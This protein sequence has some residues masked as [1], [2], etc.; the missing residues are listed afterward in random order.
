MVIVVAVVLGMI[1]HHEVQFVPVVVVRATS[2]FQVNELHPAP[3]AAMVMVW[4]TTSSPPMTII[5]SPVLVA[6]KLTEILAPPV[7][8]TFCADL[9]QATAI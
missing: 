9:T 5:T 1:A 7:G 8:R 3:V 6:V 2:V 4:E